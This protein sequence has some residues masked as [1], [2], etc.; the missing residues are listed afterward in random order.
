MKKFALQTFY[1]TIFF[2]IFFLIVNAVFFGI[3]I[4][5][6]QQVK[7]RFESMNFR[8]PNFELLVLGTSFAQYGI[9]T[10]YLT[11]QGIKSYN[12]AMDGNSFKTS[13]IQLNEYLSQ[14]KVKPKYVLLVFNS[15][16]ESMGD[17]DEIQPIVEV[18]M[19]GHKYSL[20]DFPVLK[21]RWLG[22]EVLRKTLSSK[23]RKAD[24]SFGQIKFA[25]ATCDNT[26]Y[27]EIYLDLSKTEHN[28]WIGEIAGL[29]YQND[30]ELYLIES[31]GFRETQN[32][33]AFG[34]Y[35]VRFGNGQKANL[36]NFNSRDL[37]LIFDEASDWV[38]NSHLNEFGGLKFTKELI[39]VLKDQTTKS[40]RP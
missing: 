25:K 22:T 32:L 12:L 24:L 38:G 39:K 17:Y 23:H 36:Y 9:D 15:Y 1:F 31:P 11:S 18:T 33:S 10:E 37:C 6:D 27:D 30:I 35:S 20:K 21:L 7:K 8:N 3:L 2:L 5:T 29:C 16:K 28:H 13:Y 26:V 34:P 4:T 40:L 14:Y 19:R